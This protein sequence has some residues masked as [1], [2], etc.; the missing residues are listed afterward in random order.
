MK[1]GPDLIG[2][3][4]ADGADTAPPAGVLKKIEIMRKFFFSQ[5][6]SYAI[7]IIVARQSTRAVVPHREVVFLLIQQ[8]TALFEMCLQ[9]NIRKFLTETH[10]FGNIG[11]VVGFMK[12]GYE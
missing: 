6:E 5:N 8:E 11:C 4:T 7:I 2:G 3:E 9:K 10:R 1:T 12:I